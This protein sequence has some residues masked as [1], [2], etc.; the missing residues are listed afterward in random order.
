MPTP[1]IDLAVAAA[2]RGLT[3]RQRHAAGQFTQYGLLV[4]IVAAVVFAVSRN[5]AYVAEQMFN[6]DTVAQMLPL[7][8]LAFLN[9][10]QYMLA[11]FAVG[12]TGGLVLALMK[13]YLVGPFRWLATIYIE[14]F[15]G[16]PALLV[17]TTVGFVVPILLGHDLP[18][19]TLKIA[20]A[21]G[22][23]SAAYVAETLRAGIQAVPK[24]QIEASRSLGMSQA[25]ALTTVII[26][27]GFR[28]VMP[29]LTNEVI[30]LTKDTSLVYMLGLLTQDMEITAVASNQ[31]TSASG[32]LTPL[33]LGGLCYLIITVPLGFVARHLEKKTK[34]QR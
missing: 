1:T 15:R 13:L 18:S 6:L 12:L 8:P 19:F 25:Q 23:V 30:A 14:F 16:I 10:L 9:T 26:P 17:I 27:Q 2:P 28:I 22:A 33:F 24:G 34:A 20:L 31:L 3:P 5:P 21:L 4:L 29:P 11:G 7:M 32:G